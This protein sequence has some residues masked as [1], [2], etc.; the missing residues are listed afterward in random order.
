MLIINQIY[1]INGKTI[2]KWDKKDNKYKYYYYNL[3]VNGEYKFIIFNLI[4][5]K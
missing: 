1:L 2:I 3:K 4:L 5:N